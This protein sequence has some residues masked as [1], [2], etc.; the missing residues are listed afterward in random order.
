MC[1]RD[2]VAPGSSIIS[3]SIGQDYVTAGGTS[4]SAPF[5]SATAS[6]ILSLQKFTNEEIKQ[7][8]KSTTDDIGEP[9]WDLK[10]GAGRLNMVRA[11][12]VLAPSNIK[13]SFPLMDFATSEDSFS[14]IATVL[15]ANFTS[16][17]LQVG[18]GI[19]PENWTC[20]LY[21]SPSPRDR[22]RSRMPSSA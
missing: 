16:Y 15:S 4:A 19:A 21:T 3:T 9:G 2:R 7:I 5:V 18:N 11:L 14:I 17:N 1:I 20:L 10:S 12:S 22:T 6:L 13:F 8:L